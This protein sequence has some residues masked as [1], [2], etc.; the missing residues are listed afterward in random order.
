MNPVSRLFG[1]FGG[2]LDDTPASRMGAAVA[3]A[4]ADRYDESAESWRR[5]IALDPRRIPD[6]AQAAALEPVFPR[7]AREV[8]DGLTRDGV[9]SRKHWKLVRRGSFEGEE[10]WRLEQEKHD[11][12]DE[13][14]PT[15]RYIALAVAHTSAAP[16]RLRIDCDRP[17]DDGEAYLPIVQMGEAIVTWDES[18]RIGDVKAQA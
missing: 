11:T 1:W 5:A 17:N 15:L 16:G 12:M 7:V 2:K 3:L 10:R 9:R 13:L 14:L 18:R 4:Q 8:L 6:E